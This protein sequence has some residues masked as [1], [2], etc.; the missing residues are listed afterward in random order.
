MMNESGTPQKKEP[1]VLI[2]ALGAPKLRTSGKKNYGKTRYKFNEQISSEWDI[3]LSALVE[4]FQPDRVFALCTEEAEKAFKS[5]N[6]ELTE[7]HIIPSENIVCVSIPKPGNS[8][9]INLMIKNIINSIQEVKRIHLDL[10][11]GLRSISYLGF[12]LFHLLDSLGDVSIERL[13]YM[14]Y[15][16]S[17]LKDSHLHEVLDLTDYMKLPR[18]AYAGNELIRHGNLEFLAETI[19]KLY[20]DTFKQEELE[21]THKYQER[22][23]LLRTNQIGSNAGRKIIKN[24]K[25]AFNEK[26]KHNN[27]M[28][29][30]NTKVEEILSPLDPGDLDKFHPLQFYGLAKWL[31]EHR[32]PVD[33]VLLIS[34]ALRYLCAIN[35]LSHS[36]YEGYYLD[37]NN[38]KAPSKL[39]IRDACLLLENNGKYDL[40]KKINALSRKLH[41]SPAIRNII[42]HAGIVSTSPIVNFVDIE[43]ITEEFKEIA[44][45][46]SKIDP[47]DLTS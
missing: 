32:K 42:A 15:E 23:Y 7:K 8:E 27:L 18:L 22:L 38:E 26:I 37:K 3:P 6:K 33:A 40:A 2:S 36:R 9:T 11:F 31:L 16:A 1:L 21:E 24:I 5:M 34:E 29:P 45:S 39:F 46:I 4:L 17:V 25:S 20:P 43:N 44:E 12:L 47:K 14:N 19:E 35:I 13:T 28:A 41:D 30:L 10:T